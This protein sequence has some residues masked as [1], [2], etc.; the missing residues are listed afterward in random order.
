MQAAAKPHYV[1][2]MWL[3]NLIPAKVVGAGLPIEIFYANMR[4]LGAGLLPDPDL[5]IP[6]FLMESTV[7][8]LVVGISRAFPLGTRQSA[9]LASANG[10]GRLGYAAKPIVVASNSALEVLIRQNAAPCLLSADPVIFP[11]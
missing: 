2:G 8:Q 7:Q 6:W 3:A 1:R 10:E 4:R 5:S 9:S 11:Q